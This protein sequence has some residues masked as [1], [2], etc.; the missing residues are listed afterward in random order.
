MTSPLVEDQVVDETEG[1]R[2]PSHFA[3]CLTGES[4]VFTASRQETP[5]I[6]C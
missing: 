2:L 1:M 4:L 5:A 6:L 3:F